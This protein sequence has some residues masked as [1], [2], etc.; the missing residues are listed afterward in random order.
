MKNTKHATTNYKALAP[1]IEGMDGR[2]SY[3]RFQS[4]GYMPLVS[5]ADQSNGAGRVQP[6]IFWRCQVMK[7]FI[8]VLAVAALAFIGGHA[9]TIATMEIETDGDCDSAFVYTLGREYFMGAN[10]YP[11]EGELPPEIQA[12]VLD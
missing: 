5:E 9:A 2:S 1:Y 10:G 12:L 7:K 8:A 4:E 11:I 6:E 3:R